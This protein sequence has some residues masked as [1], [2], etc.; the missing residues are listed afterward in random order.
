M[1]DPGNEV[2]DN[3][4]D[5]RPK[6]VVYFHISRLLPNDC[7]KIENYTRLI[8]ANMVNYPRGFWVLVCER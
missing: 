5:E 1:R 8:G 4:C 6:R 3:V 2:E 7:T